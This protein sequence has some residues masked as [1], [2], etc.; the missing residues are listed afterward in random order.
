[1]E[2]LKPKRGGARPGSGRPKGK[3][4]RATVEQ[5]AT[6]EQL[7]RTYTQAALATLHRVCISS[8]SDSA[9]VTAATAILDRGY[10]KP[11]QGLE[12][13]GDPQNPVNLVSRIE[14]VIVEGREPH[15]SDSDPAPLPTTH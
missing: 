4:D 13:T 1:M 3:P 5:K 10:G 11:R 8:E 7:A 15:T 2:Q 9:A 6:L 14:R 12:L